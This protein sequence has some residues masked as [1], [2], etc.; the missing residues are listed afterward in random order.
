VN[1]GKA[2]P[3]RDARTLAGL[4]LALDLDDRPGTLDDGRAGL[5]QGQERRLRQADVDEGG[6][7]PLVHM[8]DAAEIDVPRPTRLARAL[9]VKLDEAF[10]FE[11]GGPLPIATDR[12]HQA[13]ARTARRRHQAASIR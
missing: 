9:M 1:A 4:A 5:A 7:K 6:A 10:V 8:G 2:C 11:P 13:V 3:R 12:Y